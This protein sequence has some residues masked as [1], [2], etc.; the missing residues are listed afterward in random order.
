MRGKLG[1]G[2]NRLQSA[3]SVMENQSLNTQS[4]ES[5]IR[6]A[7]MAEEISNLT[8]YQILSQTGI[9]ALSQANASKQSILALMQGI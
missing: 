4:A 8:K 2:L 6:D 5:T 3:V 7:D 9:A 1:A